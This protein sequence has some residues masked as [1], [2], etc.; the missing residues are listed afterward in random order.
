M[1]EKEVT[2]T[3]YV[4][5]DGKQFLTKMEC[6]EH[7]AY[8]EQIKNI[9]YYKVFYSPDLC[10]TG[11][12]QHF[13]II[14]VNA[15]KWDNAELILEVYCAKHYGIYTEGVQG[16]GMMRAYTS[17]E[18]NREEWDNPTRENTRNCTHISNVL[19][20][21]KEVE[22]FPEKRYKYKTEWGIK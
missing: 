6:K 13:D 2:Q 15:S 19:I 5:D 20:S 10:E 8:L 16:Y 21:E 7:E 3:I 12:C 4:A 14:A 22:G 1:T 9:K 18:T 11:A 17:V